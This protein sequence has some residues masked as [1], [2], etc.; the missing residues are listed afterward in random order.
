MPKPRI[1]VTATTANCA[2]RS[3]RNRSLRLSPRSGGARM[4]SLTRSEAV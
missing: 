1:F 4:P 2:V 3:R